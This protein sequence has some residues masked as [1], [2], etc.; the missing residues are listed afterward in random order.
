MP[1]VIGGLI[2][3]G[4]LATIFYIALRSKLVDD[5]RSTFA[6]RTDVDGVGSRVNALETVAIMAKDT[7]DQ[8]SDRLLRIEA[9]G[10]EHST[11][12]SRT[13]TR[14][15]ERLNEMDTRQ[16]NDRSLIDQTAALLAEVS[17]RLDR[18]DNQRG[19]K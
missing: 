2:G 13:L 19:T 8:N 11:S 4:S 10:G 17:R 6:L 7:A 15:D 12:L 18:S 1:A 16:R 3:G 14:I 9:A 5:M